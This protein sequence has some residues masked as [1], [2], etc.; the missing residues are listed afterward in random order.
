MS[1]TGDAGGSRPSAAARTEP[2]RHTSTQREGHGIDVV[3][4]MTRQ[5]RIAW[6]GMAVLL[7]VVL[8]LAWSLFVDPSGRDG[9][10]TTTTRRV[11]GYASFVFLAG[12][13]FLV[14]RSAGL[15]VDERDRQVTARATRAGFLLPVVML[16]LIVGM[17]AM[18][19]APVQAF[20]HS[21]SPVWVSTYLMLGI[22]LSM[23]AMSAI[24]IGHFR[25]DRQ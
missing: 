18:D 24:R 20:V 16:A 22:H 17:V 7:P 25:R 14:R 1:A 8:C 6:P 4:Q 11:V 10:V 5:E 9:E 21:R 19:L 12:Y 23:V 2:G 15:R 13:Y 3:A